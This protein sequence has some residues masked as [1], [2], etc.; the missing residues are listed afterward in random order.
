MRR[1]KI[2]CSGNIESV[3]YDWNR[4]IQLELSWEQELILIEEHYPINRRI[5]KIENAGIVAR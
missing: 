3:G 2:R 1:D 5:P 4:I